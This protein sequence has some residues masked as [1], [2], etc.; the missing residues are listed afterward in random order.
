MEQTILFEIY[1]GEGRNGKPKKYVVCD[2]R[3]KSSEVFAH[4]KKLFHCAIGNIVICK[5]GFVGVHF[6][7]GKMSDKEG[8]AKAEA[9]LALKRQYPF[10]LEGVV[11]SYLLNETISFS[12]ILT[13]E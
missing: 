12:T 13:S 6:Q 4:C 1:E 8:F 2:Y 9:N 3:T 5:D 7:Q 11:L 10:E